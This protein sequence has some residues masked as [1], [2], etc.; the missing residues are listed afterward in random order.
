[1]PREIAV[2]ILSADFGNLAAD[3]SKINESVA[4]AFHL[5][6][7][8]GLFVPNISYG[9]PVCKSVASFARKPLDIH[10]MIVDPERYVARFAELHPAYISVHMEACGKSL[11]KVLRQIRECGVRPGVA[12]NPETPIEYVI[13]Y[14]HDVD[15]VLVMGV[16]PG[17]G[18]Q[19][20]I[21][22]SIEKV[23]VLSEIIAAS[24]ADCFIEFDG[25][26]NQENIEQLEKAGVDLFVAGSYAFNAGNLPMTISELSGN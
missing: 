24:E 4:V 20:L 9:F 18:G 12:I 22:E 3:C 5:D 6:I 13:P 14:L 25:G 26:V 21:L 23:E 15:Y 16:N 17:F 7:M 2:S 10:L 11:R 1:M 8:D 19:S